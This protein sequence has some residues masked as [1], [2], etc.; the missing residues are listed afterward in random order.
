L[1]KTNTR[2]DDMLKVIRNRC[3]LPMLEKLNDQF[4]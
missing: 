2:S 1:K 4:S 3:V